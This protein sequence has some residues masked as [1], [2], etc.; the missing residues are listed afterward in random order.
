MDLVSE[1]SKALFFRLFLIILIQE[2]P[3]L[4]SYNSWLA[5]VHGTALMHLYGFGVG[6][7]VSRE[8]AV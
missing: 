6:T 1:V 4:L 3:L 8:D 2:E 5:Y 7:G